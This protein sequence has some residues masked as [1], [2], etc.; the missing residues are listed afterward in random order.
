MHW[1]DKEDLIIKAKDM[2]KLCEKLADNNLE[3][4][5]PFLFKMIIEVGERT[6][7]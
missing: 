7:K 2:H 3:A 4:A 6:N 1:I 5:I